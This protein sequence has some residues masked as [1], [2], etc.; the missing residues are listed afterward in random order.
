MRP[1]AEGMTPA[2]LYGVVR[3]ITG[4]SPV[5]QVAKGPDPDRCKTNGPLQPAGP[6]SERLGPHSPTAIPA[7][8]PVSPRP[9]FLA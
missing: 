5:P 8:S 9:T 3:F 6:Q 2:E 1:M 4:K 7:T